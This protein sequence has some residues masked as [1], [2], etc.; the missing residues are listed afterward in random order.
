[1]LIKFWGARGSIPVS[2][3]EYL[4]YGGD[5]TCVEL[6]AAGGEVVIIDAGSGI[7]R[8]GKRL[9][10]EGRQS[11]ILLFTHSH[12]D[13]VMGFPFF[14]PIYFKGTR[15]RMMGCPFAQKAV[16]DVIAR[17]MQPPV[18]PVKFDD[19]GAKFAY[20]E[21]C[22][23]PFRIGG[24][25]V[26][27]VLLSHPN[28]GLGYRFIERGKSFVFL[29]DNELGLVHPGGLALKDYVEFC[30][31]ADLLVHDCEYLDS[32][33]P[34][35]RAWGH[36]T[37][38]Q[39]LRLAL[40]SSVRRLGLFHHNQERTDAQIDAM[41]RECRARIRRERSRLKCFAVSEGL[42]IRL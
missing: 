20:S 38:S 7:R 12:W 42:T 41:V 36:S 26:E 25:R 18:F 8:L 4:R 14:L 31:G 27:P 1:M 3:R 29:T 37:L 9:M 39:A 10:K 5:T 35:R 6:R 11:F 23:E 34:K 2:G 32:E 22:A 16:K 19:I 13:H 21:I 28:R 15:L 24:M 30:R 17:T 33:Y 40:A